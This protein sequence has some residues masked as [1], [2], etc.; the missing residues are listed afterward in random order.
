MGAFPAFQIAPPLP[1]IPEHMHGEMFVAIVACWAGP[2]EEGERQFRPFHE[3]AEVKAELVGPVPYPAINAAFDGLFPK[4]IRQY[5]KGNFVKELSDG[6]IAAHVEHGPKAPTMSSTMHLYPIDGACHRVGPHD[7]AFGHRD[8]N[9]SMVIVSAWTDPADDAANTRWVRDYAEAL[10]P[11]S[12][13]GGYINFMA[14]DDDDRIKANY[15]E[16][17]DRLVEVKRKFD[18]GNLFRLNQNIRP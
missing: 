6:A 15:G 14:A 13:R 11:F 5:W 3:V 8:A 1:F 10:S 2:L 17:Y 7:T 9:W 4:G 12:E 18:P 16:N